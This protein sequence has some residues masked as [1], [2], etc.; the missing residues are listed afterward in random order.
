MQCRDVAR[1]VFTDQADIACT[2]RDV[3]SV[4]C[5]SEGV[6]LGVTLCCLQSHLLRHNWQSYTWYQVCCVTICSASCCV[7]FATP[8][9]ALLLGIIYHVCCAT[10]CNPSCCVVFAIPFVAELL[11]YLQSHLLR[12][13]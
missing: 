9:V 12:Y 3:M 13:Y 5:S 6:L 10:I 11:N 2:K 4:Q 7:V 1:R 8:F